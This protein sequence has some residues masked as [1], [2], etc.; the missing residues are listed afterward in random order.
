MRSEDGAH[1]KMAQI[2]VITLHYQTMAKLAP[3]IVKRRI[4]RALKTR[5]VFPV[6]P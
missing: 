6:V 3:S 4:K 5:R 1:A 2:A